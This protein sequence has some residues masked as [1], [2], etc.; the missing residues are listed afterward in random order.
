MK[1]TEIME[2]VCDTG[3]VRSSGRWPCSVCRKEL[4]ETLSSVFSVNIGCI[5][6]AVARN[7]G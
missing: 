2:S 5:R 7:V 1:N 6:V 3:S 4:A